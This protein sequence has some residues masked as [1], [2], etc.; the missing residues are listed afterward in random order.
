MDLLNCLQ[1]KYYIYFDEIQCR[2]SS[3]AC[4]SKQQT[5]GN[6][7]IAIIVDSKTLCT[8]VPITCMLTIVAREQ[9][10]ATHERL[11]RRA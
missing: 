8:T 4:C 1:A 10:A 7:N 9:R 5:I 11:A 6:A 3:F 2:P